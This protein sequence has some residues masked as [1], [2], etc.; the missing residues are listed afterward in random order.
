M[1]GRQYGNQLHQPFV[2][3]K[4]YSFS[5]SP[6]PAVVAVV[7]TRI[8]ARTSVVVV[9]LLGLLGLGL[10]GLWSRAISTIIVPLPATTTISSIIVLVTIVGLV[11]PTITVVVI[12]S[13]HVV[14]AEAVVVAVVIHHPLSALLAQFLYIRYNK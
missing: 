8:V 3:Y 13:V 7:G 4:P 2:T 5:G 12:V 14:V 6:L 1:H 9:S 10:L 11:S